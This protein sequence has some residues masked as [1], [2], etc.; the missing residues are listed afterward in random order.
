MRL[1]LKRKVKLVLYIILFLFLVGMLMYEINYSQSTLKTKKI[2]YSKESE[3]NYI[4]Y[5]KD[6]NHYSENFLKEDYN[7]VANL[8]DYFNVD[9]N[10]TYALSESID[11]ILTYEVVGELDIYDSDTKN[12]PIDHKE[13]QIVPKETIS[14]TGQVVKI[15]L[16]NK[17]IKYDTY[18]KIIEE[19]KK[20]ISP[21]AKLKVT[22]KVN[23]T[24]PSTLLNKQIGD[25]FSSTFEI[26]VSEKIINIKKPTNTIEK[27][28]VI[29]A[30]QAFGSNFYVLTGSTL[31]IMFLSFMGII[32]TIMILNKNKSKYE[33]KVKK[34]LR[35]FDRAITEAKGK[36]VKQPGEHYIE[37]KEFMELMDV[38]DNLNEPIIYYRHSCNKSIFVVRNGTDIYYWIIRRDDYE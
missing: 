24:A 30:N 35:E 15:N 12:K 8:V 23:W 37:V 10:Y 9:Y 3:I 13:Y 22:F 31:L 14:G 29:Y 16:F 33:H 4:A 38:H 26:P 21:E 36:F 17:V 5:L 2:T 6:N 25:S 7:Y 27:N 18:S 32:N 11:Y 34:I 20:D 1:R 19:W 28:K